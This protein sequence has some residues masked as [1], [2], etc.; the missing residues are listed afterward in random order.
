MRYWQ[1]HLDEL[2]PE[3]GRLHRDRVHVRAGDLLGIDLTFGPVTLS[4]GV[5]VTESSP[6]R[7]TVLSPQGHA[8]AGWTKFEVA[9]VEDGTRA[10]ITIEMRASDPLFELG[11][12]FGGHR[13]EERFWAEMLRNLA[14]QFGGRA[15][16][17]L[18]RRRLG[19]SRQWKHFSNVRH[20]ATILTT[21]RRISR[22]LGRIE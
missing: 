2:W 14:A 19:A 11:L 8:F 1:D 22:A 17:R 15:T 9:D 4:T 18:T 3:R 6:T 7:F 5:V 16:V 13:S 12:M 21:F 20:N 10:S